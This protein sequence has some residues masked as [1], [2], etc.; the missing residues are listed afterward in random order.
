[1][2]LLVMAILTSH[3]GVWCSDRESLL[4]FAD[5]L[6]KDGEYYRAITEYRRF[7]SYYP[8]DPRAGQIDL[9]IAQCLLAG[10]SPLESVEWCRNVRNK[11]SDTELRIKTDFTLGRGYLCLE[12]YKDAQATF[13]GILKDGDTLA[14]YSDEGRFLLAISYVGEERWKEAS[15]EFSNV[16]PACPLYDRAF[17]YSKEVMKGGRLPRKNTG[18]AT[19]LSLVPGLGY[20]YTG[21]KGTGMASLVVNG[22]FAWGTYSAFRKKENGV[23]VVIGL[24]S[25]GWYTG[26]IYGGSISA[27]RFNERTLKNF[28]QGFSW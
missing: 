6:T 8:D 22:L 19:A 5:G 20:I 11:Y 16:T 26:N 24:F 18:L 13:K 1:M 3:G 15:R 7:I 17:K 14:G 9:K 2:A 21:N 27:S 23:G 12:N 4:S 25:L 10:G 28:K